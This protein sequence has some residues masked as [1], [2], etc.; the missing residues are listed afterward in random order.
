MLQD[1]P[2]KPNTEK[3]INR[4]DRVNGDIY[5][6]LKKEDIRDKKLL[7][8]TLGVRRQAL[9]IMQKNGDTKCCHM[10]KRRRAQGGCL[11]TESR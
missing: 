8:A 4:K 9:E 3:S 11:G 1:V 7:S 2:G 5:D 10:V 6:S